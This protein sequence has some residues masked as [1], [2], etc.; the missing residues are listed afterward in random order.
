MNNLAIT[1]LL[2]TVNLSDEDIEAIKDKLSYIYGCDKKKILIIYGEK[3]KTGIIITNLD[4]LVST[5]I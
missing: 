1:L 3:S 5:S 2:D 4:T